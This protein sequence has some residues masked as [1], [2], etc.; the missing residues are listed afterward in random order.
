MGDFRQRR[1]LFVADDLVAKLELQRRQY[2]DQ[3]G[4]AGSL[5][6]PVDRTLHQSR[7]TFN[8][9]DRRGGPTVRIVMRMDAYINALSE[10]FDHSSRYL[11]H[12]AWQG[13]AVGIAN[14]DVLCPALNRTSQ[15]SERVFR[16]FVVGIEEMLGVVY[17]PLALL[18]QV[19]DRL[20]D[21]AQILIAIHLDHLLDVQ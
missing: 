1:Y 11:S 7:T 15:A 4:V 20:L 21:H 9:S 8:R 14:R 12:P 6:V 19:R 3:V 16:I 10:V 18:Q 5:T 2:R 17:D 13:G